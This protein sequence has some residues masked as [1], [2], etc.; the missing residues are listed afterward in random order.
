MCLAVGALGL[1]ACAPKGSAGSDPSDAL[2]KAI[3]KTLDA[4]SLRMA[5]DLSMNGGGRG[6]E[7]SGDGEL[8]LAAPA[9]H[10]TVQ[11]PSFGP[12]QPAGEVE[13]ILTDRVVYL[14]AP[15]LQDAFGVKTPWVSI[16]PTE[17]G[18][19]HANVP[20][21]S[22]QYDPAKALDLLR[23]VTEVTEEG[24]DTIGG[25]PAVRYRATVDLA[26]A[27]HRVV[28]Q[29]HLPTTAGDPTSELEKVLGSNTK[30]P[31]DLW[32]ADG[33]VVRVRVDF[34][35]PSE[36]AMGQDVRLVMTASLSDF[37]ATFDISPPPADQ[38]TDVTKRL[39]AHAEAAGGAWAKN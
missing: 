23:G 25:R 8:V 2:A 39:A 13:M 5:Y 6:F 3:Q 18:A 37:G 7:I 33:Y 32:V 38:V 22:G 4:G 28:Q 26:K 14:K 17:L 19:G 24:T 11:F 31:I 12:G 27:M 30:L 21:G 1:A 16:D 29:A 34:P 10:M 20:D 35:F 36:L 9:A 15:F